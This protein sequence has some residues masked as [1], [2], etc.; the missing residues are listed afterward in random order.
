M[1]RP[2][3]LGLFDSIIL[4]CVKMAG[5]FQGHFLAAITQDG[6][7]TRIN[8]VLADAITAGT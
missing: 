5:S 8:E 6:R 4:V 7:L 1:Y 3:P 2:Q